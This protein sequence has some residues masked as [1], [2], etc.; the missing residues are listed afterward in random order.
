MRKNIGRF[1]VCIMTAVVVLLSC[2][3]VFAAENHVYVKELKMNMNLPEDMPAITRESSQTDK[4]F[5]IFGLDFDETMQQFKDANIYLQGMFEDSS[6]ILT[7]SMVSTSD[8]QKIGSYSGLSE[9]QLQTVKNTFEA[10]NAYKSCTVEKYND[11]VFFNLLMEIQSGNETVTAYQANTVVNGM[12]IAVMLQ[13]SKGAQLQ[14]TDYQMLSGVL[15]SIVFADKDLSTA[16]LLDS[17]VFWCVV[18]CVAV[19]LILILAVLLLKKHKTRR[20]EQKMQEK[21]AQNASILMELSREF[22]V[23]S[24][25]SEPDLAEEDTASSDFSDSDPAGS[26]AEALY[27]PGTEEQA[28]EVLYQEDNELENDYTA[29][30][31]QEE[32]NFESPTFEESLR[33][34]L[35]FS[36]KELESAQR[37]MQNKKSTVPAGRPLE[38]PEEKAVKILAEENLISAAAPDADVFITGEED[39]NAAESEKTETEETAGSASEF[40]QSDDYFDE[41][42]DEEELYFRSTAQEAMDDSDRRISKEEAKKKAKTAGAVILNGILIAA[43]GVKSFFIHL[44]YFF[45]NLFRFIKYKNGIRKRKKAEMQKRRQQEE[46]ERRR[47]ENQQ[48]R[49]Q[50]TRVERM[51]DGLVKVHSRQERQR[52]SSKRAPG[53]RTPVKRK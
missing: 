2:F 45:T 42:P 52:V 17:P 27:E 8:S 16:G 20:N 15:Q 10:E 35:Q 40:E 4:Y 41:A 34:T 23:G 46:A 12:S 28:G 29:S 3:S 25:H 14:E 9:E 32:E 30:A 1:S 19:L 33:Q 22:A 31:V 11:L 50:R 51:E 49:A 37:A 6:R 13:P 48:R 21:K 36:Q 39:E 5:S 18:I 26:V 43:N 47:R 53:E 7:V 38:V 24:N 44:G